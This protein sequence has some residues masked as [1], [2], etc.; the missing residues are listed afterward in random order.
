M[1]WSSQASGITAKSYIV[2][3]IDGSVLLE[4]NA[5]E[6]RPIASITKLFTAKAASAYNPSELITIKAEDLKLGR[7]HTSMLK[8]GSSYT[9][10]ALVHL[11][12]IKSDNAAA[13]A[14]SRSKWDPAVFSERAHLVE[15]SGLDPSNV[16]SARDLAMFANS[17]V[18]TE[19][20]KISVKPEVTIGKLTRRSTNKLIRSPNWVF[21]LSK[22]GF[23][24]QSGGC[25]LVIFESKGRLVTTAILGSRDVPARWSDLIELRRLIESKRL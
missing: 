18:N 10:S 8:A 3:E 4:K 22:T 7:S 25:V 2:T 21:H 23:I 20:A 1:L 5:D 15:A 12:L 17:L 16:S 6:I 11:A 9:R 24:N 19:L 13:I 14:L